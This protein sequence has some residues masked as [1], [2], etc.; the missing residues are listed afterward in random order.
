MLPNQT[1]VCSPVL[2]KANLLTSGCGEGKYSV[3]CREPSKENVQ[4]MLQRPE[5][6]DGFQGR[7][8]K[9]SVRE[10][11]AGCV[12]SLYKIFGLVGIKVNFPPS[13]FN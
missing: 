12:I 7:G 8:F 11:A 1:W 4:L 13:G 5:L 3:Y 9:G 10:G 6:P 2:S